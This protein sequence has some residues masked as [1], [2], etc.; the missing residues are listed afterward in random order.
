M[1]CPTRRMRRMG[2]SR[3]TDAATLARSCGRC[4]TS[5]R[6]YPLNSDTPPQVAGDWLHEHGWTLADVLEW[7]AGKPCAE[8]PVSSGKS[9]NQPAPLCPACF[10]DPPAEYGRDVLVAFIHAGGATHPKQ[11]EIAAACEQLK[12]C[13]RPRQYYIEQEWQARGA[14]SFKRFV[15]LLF[16][17]PADE[18]GVR[19]VRKAALDWSDDPWLL[20]IFDRRF[21]IQ[22]APRDAYSRICRQ[23]MTPEQLLPPHYSPQ[24]R[25]HVRFFN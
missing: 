23:E 1:K 9:H 21:K 22:N 15:L 25:P 10:A 19:I 12:M 14:L 4:E 5:M 7:F 3:G 6:E 13:A 11:L 16:S 24:P 8:E 2:R 18:G 20:G 17:V